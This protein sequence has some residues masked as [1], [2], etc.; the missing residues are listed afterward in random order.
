M[1]I[2]AHIA[3]VMLLGVPAMVLHECGHVVTALMCGVKVK[4]VG[5]CRKGFYTVRE[6]GPKWSN[7]AVSA[8]GPLINL[9]LAIMFWNSMT[10][11]AEVNLVACL[12]NLLPIPNSDGTRILALLKTTS[13]LP[14]TVPH[15]RADV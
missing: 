2:L 7:V 4:R 10:T 5:L 13:V 6:P 8:A 3:Y 12:Y 1:T 11:F 15:M 9:I 14:Q